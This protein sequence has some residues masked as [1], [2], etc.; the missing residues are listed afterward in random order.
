MNIDWLC[1]CVCLCNCNRMDSGSEI[2]FL[3]HQSEKTVAVEITT[4][5]T[6]AGNNVTWA[7]LSEFFSCVFSSLTRRKQ[8]HGDRKLNHSHCEGFFLCRFLPESPVRQSKIND[9]WRLPAVKKFRRNKILLSSYSGLQTEKRHQFCSSGEALTI[10]QIAS[11]KQ[12]CINGHFAGFTGSES[13]IFI[14]LIW[15]DDHDCCFLQNKNV[16]PSFEN[17]TM[18]VDWRVAHQ[19]DYICRVFVLFE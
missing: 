16:L 3:H 19:K 2:L 7:H 9:C 11:N 6:T 13:L 12:S 1:S 10:R 5:A 15:L 4:N 17:G 8:A 18:R 14:P